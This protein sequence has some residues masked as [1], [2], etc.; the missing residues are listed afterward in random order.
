MLNNIL[1]ES[2]IIV[3][4]VSNTKR[5]AI[6]SISNMLA[7]QYR[8]DSQQIFTAFIARENEISTG[9]VNGVAIPHVLMNDITESSINVVRLEKKLSDWSTLDNT[10]VDCLIVLSGPVPTDG[11]NEHLKILSTFARMLMHDS[12]LELIKTG[13]CNEINEKIKELCI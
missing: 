13:T 1:K 2:N 3:D 6:K 10:E 12:F 4:E 11:A 5:E 9:M 8:I 7:E